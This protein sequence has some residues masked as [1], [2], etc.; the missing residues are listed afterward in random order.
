MPPVYDETGEGFMTRITTYAAV[1]AIWAGT[2]FAQ[3]I[4]K[5][6]VTDAP[7][8][9]NMAGMKMSRPAVRSTALT[10]TFAEKT[11]TF[12]PESLAALPHVSLTA[13]NEHAKANQTYSGVP[14][15]ALLKTLGVTE[16]PHGKDLRL[17]LVAEG[18]DGYGAVFAVAEVNSD[19]H[20]GTVIVADSMD[21]RPLGD[22]GVFQLIGSEEKHPARWVRNLSAI[23]VKSA[24]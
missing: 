7:G 9:D 17:Y 22:N 23:K 3:E 18:A 21:G 5:P 15:M 12:T 6:P 16:K 20:N 11:G 13:F 4:P 19:I 8:M 1:F 14:V 2:T 10:V 24:E